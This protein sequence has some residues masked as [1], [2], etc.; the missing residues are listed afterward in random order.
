MPTGLS[1]Q[2]ICDALSVLTSKGQSTQGP[3][4]QI[5]IVNIALAVSGFGPIPVV[6]ARLTDIVSTT[7]TI[8]NQAAG[9]QPLSSKSD[10][11]SVVKSFTTLVQVYQALL[12]ILIGKAG[13]VPN[14]LPFVGPPMAS[15]LRQLESVLDTLAYELIDMVPDDKTDVQNQKDSLDQTL[16][17]AI[18]AWDANV[19]AKL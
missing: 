2:D 12:N 9:A 16:S 4:N 19:Q 17:N 7:G 14:L 8:I 13:I 5:N 3:A 6:I 1:T 15:V 18:S 10:Q 11:D